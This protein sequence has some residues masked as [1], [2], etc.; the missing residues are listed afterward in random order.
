MINH[1]L[2]DLL[3]SSQRV[4]LLQGPVGE[5]FFE[6]GK[7]LKL[8]QKMVYKINFNGGDEFFYPNSIENTF[9]Y[10]EH[11]VLLKAYLYDFCKHHQ[12]DAIVCFGDNRPCHKIAKKIANLLNINF[13]VFEEGYFRPH[14]VTLEKDGV[15]AYSPFPKNANFFLNLKTMLK[16]PEK[17][18]ALAK[19]FISIANRA[20]RYYWE[21]YKNH[22]HYSNYSHHRILDPKYYVKR[23]MISAIKRICYWSRERFFAYKVERCRFGDFFI[24]PLQVYNDSQVKEHSD[25]KSVEAFLRTVLSSFVLKAPAHFKLIVKHHPMDRGFID[26]LA[27]INEFIELYPQLKGRVFYVYDVPLPVFLRKGM[28]MVTLN[29]TSGLSAL[30]HGMPVKTLGRANYDFAGLT[31]QGDL[32]EFWFAP[33]APNEEVFTVYR[34]FHLNKTQING[35]FY[36]K[37]LLKGK[38][39]DGI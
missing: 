37:V 13:W 9:S 30:L 39:N 14:Y 26:Y 4:L 17:P 6:F 27:V 24:V 32:D 8:N 20:I 38:E 22:K 18:Q 19:G 31:H 11:F 12:I 2:D 15:N 5:F 28:G 33:Q 10:K 23:W 3:N 7:W 34:A 29:S 21:A 35:S 36:N 25:Y 16:E 1:Y